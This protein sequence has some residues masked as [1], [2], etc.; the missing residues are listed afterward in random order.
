MC[1]HIP[2]KDVRIEHMMGSNELRRRIE[3]IDR[4]ISFLRKKRSVMLYGHEEID[5]QIEDL[6]DQKELLRDDYRRQKQSF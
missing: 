3:E 1:N 5:R 4:Q 6:E 2:K